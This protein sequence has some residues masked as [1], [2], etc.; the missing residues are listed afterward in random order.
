MLVTMTTAPISDTA[1]APFHPAVQEWFAAS[2]P[3]P[4]RAQQLGWPAI[5]KGDWTLIFAP[6]GSGKTL[7]A[8]LWALDRLMFTPRPP[9]EQRCRVIYISPLKALAVDVERNLRAPLAGIANVARER[10]D[11]FV[12]PE[13]A[14]R[15]GDTP[16]SERARFGRHPDHDARIA[17]PAD[18]VE[19]ARRPARRRDRD[20]RRDPRARP[21]QTR[22]AHGVVAGADG[23]AMREAAAADRALGDATAV[24]GSGEV[25]R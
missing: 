10:G 3:S 12:I 13:I 8:F 5:A 23:A 4:T 11:D 6:T 1:L 22:R 2:F 19:R 21:R 18:D 9:K 24:G 17:L 7:T 16:Q 20:H 14:T 15:T 25:F